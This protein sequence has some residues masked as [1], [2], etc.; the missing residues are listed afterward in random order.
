MEALR[1]CLADPKP[2]I[3]EVE[4]LSLDLHDELYLK[5]QEGYTPA[6][7]LYRTDARKSLELAIDELLFLREKLRKREHAIFRDQAL[8][9][10]LRPPV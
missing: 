1:C 2:T 8:R 3:T 10:R 7:Y 5:C 6:A 4:V 9:N